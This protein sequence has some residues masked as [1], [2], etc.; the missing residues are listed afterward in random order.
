M[1]P[2]PPSLKLFLGAAFLCAAIGKPASAAEHPPATRTRPNI[3]VAIADDWSFGHAGAYDCA[4]VKTPGFDRVA[5]EGVLFNRFYTPSAKCSPSRSAI[6]TGRNPWQLGPAAN[7]WPTFPPEFRTYPEVLALQG[8]FVGMTMKGWG[9]GDANDAE[10]KPRRMTGVPFNA[11]K[12]EP[13]TSEISKNDYAANFQDF[14]AASPAGKPW[15]FW[16]GSVEPHRAYEYGSGVAKGDKKLSDIE[17]VPSMWPDTERVRNDLLDYAY[18]VEHFDRHLVR[19]LEALEARGELENTLV[20]VMADNGMP[21]PRSK[22]QN[23]EIANHLPLAIRWPAGIPFSSR[24]VDDYVSVIDLAPT[25]LEVAGV[26]WKES[27]MAPPTGRSLLPLLR[28]E[29]SGILDA[30]RDHVLLGRERNDVG[31]PHDEGYPVRSIVKNG[32]LY[33]RNYE[34]DRW[35]GGNPET[36]YLDCDS[37]PTKTEILQAHRKNKADPYW[38]LAFGKREDEELY[39]LHSDPDCI[40]NLA[41]VADLKPLKE[42]LSAQLSAELR[43]QEDPRMLGRGGEFDAY[44]YADSRQRGFYDR[45][46]RGEPPLKAFNKEDVDADPLT[47]PAPR[48]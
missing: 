4:W 1:R 30:T 2:L 11:H 20:I 16:Y 14:L 25:V 33:A 48:E 10:G 32:L 9:P 38:A 15:C 22:G 44:P 27:G 21:F 17:R 43:A 47:L 37:S 39:D 35:P 46:K 24:I 3:L 8:Y 41:G 40:Q 26:D 28:A 34:A 7:H 13:P 31:R 12:A 42:A 29:K 18:E 45:H 23:Y 19:M 36:G 5:R 6:L